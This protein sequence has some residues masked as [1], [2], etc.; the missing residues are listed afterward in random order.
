MNELEKEVRIARERLK[1]INYAIAI[2][3]EDL[4]IRGTLT[5]LEAAQ[6]VKLAVYTGEQS[7]YY[8]NR[9]RG[10]LSKYEE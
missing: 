7:I 6:L 4:R 10:L 8:A 5:L 1:D 2:V 3:Q 9:L